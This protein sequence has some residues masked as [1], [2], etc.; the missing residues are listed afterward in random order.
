[1][2]IRMCYRAIAGLAALNLLSLLSDTAFAQTITN[3]GTTVL[4]TENHTITVTP[5][6]PAISSYNPYNGISSTQTFTVTF[7]RD[8]QGVNNPCRVGVYVLAGNITK[9]LTNGANTLNYDMKVSGTS[10]L[11]PL[12]SP[13]A[14]APIILTANRNSS[15]Q[16]TITFEVPGNQVKPALGT[17]Y[18]DNA[19]VV[20]TSI[21]NSNQPT[22]TQRTRPI[23]PQASVSKTC[24][25]GTPSATTLAFAAGDIPNGL[26]NEGV[27]KTTSMSGSCTAPSF[28]RLSGQA[29]QQ[30]PAPPPRSGFDNFI[31]YTATST[32]SSGS[33]TLNTTTTPQTVSTPSIGA[34]N[35]VVSGSVAV[36]VNLKKAN[37]VIA[38]SYS[39][40]L[41]ISLEP[42]P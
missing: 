41:T 26:P 17:A 38:G 11:S 42:A 31:N 8:N 34:A 21:N 6:A 20:I 12:G 29:L 28:L 30:T 16:A 10:V 13:P 32:F 9:V 27:A 19:T 23:T 2:V 7:T 35:S 40:T 1:M 15:D 39:G 36:S 24:V 18:A 3:C 37:P 22:G 5:A 33:V 4:N 25:F 14:K